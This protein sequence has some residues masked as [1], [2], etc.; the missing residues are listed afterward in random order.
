MTHQ[1]A[2]PL[3]CLSMMLGSSLAI[4]GG[5]YCLVWAVFSQ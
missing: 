5:L 2:S 3:V 1:K 4:W